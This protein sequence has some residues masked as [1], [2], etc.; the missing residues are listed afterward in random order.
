MPMPMRGLAAAVTAAAL[1]CG[2]TAAAARNVAVA[3]ALAVGE[4]PATCAQPLGPLGA[5]HRPAMLRDARFYVHD[6]ALVDQGGAAVPLQLD[7]SPWQHQGV[8]LL[9][10]AD[11]GGACAGGSAATNPAVTGTL[12]DGRYRGLRLTLGVP[13]ALNHSSTELAPPP[14]DLAAMG[15]GWQAGRKFVKI[16]IDPEGGIARADGTRAAT[17]FIHLGSTGCSGKAMA[18]QVTC[19]RPNRVPLAFGDF[20][21]DRDV[22]T[23]DLAALLADSGLGADGGGAVGC[24]A[25]PADPECDAVFAALGLS[26]ATGRPLATGPAPAFAIR[27]RP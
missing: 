25:A 13:E 18:G 7:D 21:A 24:M 3:F 14:L 2:S 19:A 5:D 8:A 17:W 23:L 22:V 15:W 4:R 10:F 12:P 6:V 20:D 27:P 26:P 16:E 1:G 9:D 11:D